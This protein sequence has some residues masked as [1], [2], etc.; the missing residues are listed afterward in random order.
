MKIGARPIVDYAQQ[1][2]LGSKTGL[3]LIAES[4]GLMPTDEFMMKAHKRRLGGGDVANLSI[5]QGDA[6]VTPLQLAQAMGVIANGGT[7]YQTRLVEQVQSIDGQIVNAYNVR[8]R[9]QVEID[10]PVIKTIKR[11]MVNVVS[12]RSGTAGRA[13]V[14]NVQ[15]AGKTG[16]AQW[17]PKNR[18]R[19]AAW[20]AG[21]A[22]ADDPKYAFAVV[23]E[24]AANDNS[25]HGGTAAA[26]IAGK[27]LREIFKDQKPQKKKK[28][29]DADNDEES[30]KQ[31]DD[32][33][34]APVR[35]DRAPTPRPQQQQQQ[36]ERKSF[37]KR[38]FGG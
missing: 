15:V 22:P 8:A 18:E 2:G 26:P 37:W 14:P 9:S 30:D 32:E 29:E 21:F 6:L 19:T 34:D 16:T 38:L 17:G 25:V 7:L 1:C 35:R 33:E 31:M 20:F 3:P 12:S 23:Y 10:K 24:G 36:P 27:V 5:G 4:E 13:A 11:G 28:K